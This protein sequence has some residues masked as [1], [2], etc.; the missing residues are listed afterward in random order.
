VAVT[1]ISTTIDSSIVPNTQEINTLKVRMTEQEN[2]LSS[3]VTFATEL[4]TI[5]SL[6]MFPQNSLIKLDGLTIGNFTLTL[7]PVLLGTVT[8]A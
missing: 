6:L 1:V 3:K 7:V 5:N 2:L 4:N 8:L